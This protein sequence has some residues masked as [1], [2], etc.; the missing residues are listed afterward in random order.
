MEKPG[1]RFSGSELPT[2]HSHL[3]EG[4]SGFSADTCFFGKLPAFLLCIFQP[5]LSVLPCIWEVLLKIHYLI[6]RCNKEP[7]EGTVSTLGSM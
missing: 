7:K 5:F 2:C 4:T 3:E 6:Q 1:K